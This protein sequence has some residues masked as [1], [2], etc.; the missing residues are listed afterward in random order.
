MDILGI[1]VSMCKNHAFEA[2]LTSNGVM[3]IQYEIGKIFEYI[4][5]SYYI[6]LNDYFDL[7]RTNIPHVTNNYGPE[8]SK[9]GVD[10]Y[11]KIYFSTENWLI[12]K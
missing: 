5:R 1:P 10:C 3:N 12:Y 8:K 6:E 9:F 7:I 2:I 11:R 4:E